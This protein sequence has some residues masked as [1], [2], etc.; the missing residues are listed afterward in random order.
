MSASDDPIVG[1]VTVP[2]A[3]ET[4]GGRPELGE[5][6]EAINAMRAARPR[7]HALVSTVA[8]PLVANVAAALAVDISMTVEMPDVRAMITSSDAVLINLG[9]LDKAR[10][11][12]AMAAVATGTRFVLDPVKVD[13]SGDRLG[14][15]QTL[16]SAQPSII[17]GNRGEMAAL[18]PL[19]SDA[20]CVTTGPMDEVA[21]P[22]RRII[23]ANDTPIL[24]RVI[25]TG[26]ATG[27]LMTAIHAVEPNPFVA[28]LAGTALMAVAGELAAEDARLPGSFAV[29]LIDKIADLNGEDVARHVKLI[30]A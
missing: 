24:G 7:I 12:A 1:P 27:F 21:A 4:V 26:C 6:A 11:E 20:V 2:A 29:A 23:V 16:V 10:R 28:A 17:K 9:M 8:Q 15:A 3:T 30:D 19:D 14:F 13:R 25:A 22:D 5:I 18:A